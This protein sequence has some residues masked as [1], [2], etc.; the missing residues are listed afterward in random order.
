[1]RVIAC[2]PRDEVALRYVAPLLPWL[3][4]QVLAIP[5]EAS[6]MEFRFYQQPQLDQRM[7]IADGRIDEGDADKLRTVAR[8]A[9]RDE[10]GLVT[11][12]LNSPGGNVEAAFRIVDVMDKIR[13]Y[14]VVPDNA[15]CA[16]ACASIMFASGERRSI[17]G[18][19]QLGFHSCYKRI[20]NSYVSDS[21]CNEIVAANAMQRGV[22]HA[23][24]NRFIADHGARDMA[25]VGRGVACRSLQ[26]LCR[27]G[28]LENV[29]QTRDALMRSLDCSKLTT[30]PLQLVCGDAELASVDR[31]LVSLYGKML[32]GSANKARFRDG[33]RDWLRHS[34]NQCADK[35]CLMR[36][37]RLRIDELQR[38]R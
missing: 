31:E 8:L 26:G 33:Q 30:M 29:P 4:L 27:P 5:V 21:L 3:C 9:D 2:L 28:K 17:L 23:A 15:R 34:R 35:A 1:M 10:E 7:I 12:I 18:S 36:A 20:A 11:L 25:W 32:K 16:S 13:V 24:I 37:Y 6:G 19:G 22:S 14:T 38:L